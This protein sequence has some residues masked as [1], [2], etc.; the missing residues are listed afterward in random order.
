MAEGGLGD[1]EG[2]ILGG[3]RE[4]SD[5]DVA[6]ALGIEGRVEIFC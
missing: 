3:G 2:S 6:L 5:S 1:K 4:M